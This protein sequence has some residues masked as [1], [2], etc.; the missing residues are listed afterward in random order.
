QGFYMGEHGWF[1]KRWMYEESFR[2]PM[3]M[4]YPALLR[5]NSTIN[6]KIVNA[7]IA[8][9]LLELAAIKKPKDMQGESFVHVLKNNKEEH[10]K[11]LFYHY[12]EN[13]EHAVS[14]HFG[15]RDDRY[16]L[17]RYYKRIE[18]WELFDLQKDPNELHNVYKDPAYQ[19]VVKLMKKKLITQMRQ[20][21]DKE[22]EAIYKINID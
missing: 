17:I 12:F 19:S 9:T 15:V 6:A 10:R 4:R 14:P 21:D 5:A 13:G 1:D 11:D 16:K 22:A 2:T 7:D 3:V 18:N 20:F 8:P